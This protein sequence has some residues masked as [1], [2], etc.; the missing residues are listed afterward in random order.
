MHW[1]PSKRKLIADLNPEQN[2]VVHRLLLRWMVF[3]GFIVTK[4]HRALQFDQKPYMKTVIDT[5]VSKRSQ[6][7]MKV[8]KEF[9]I[10]I[11]NSACGKMCESVQKRSRC[12][13]VTT[14]KNFA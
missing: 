13:I 14:P 7:K 12:D 11:L 6:A 9:Y 10:L 2:I 5:F 4:T 3:N 8:K 1:V